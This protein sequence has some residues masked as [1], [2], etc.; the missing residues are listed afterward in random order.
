MRNNMG[1]INDRNKIDRKEALIQYM[2]DM[3]IQKYKYKYEYTPEQLHDILLLARSLIKTTY[4]QQSREDEEISL[5]DDEIPID[6]P[7]TYKDE[8][9]YF[10]AISVLLILFSFNLGVYAYRKNIDRI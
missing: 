1:N 10:G 7:D 3:E 4:Q 5:Y 9:D 6:V 2:I 8:I